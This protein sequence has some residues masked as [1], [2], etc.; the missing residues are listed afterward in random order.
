MSTLRKSFLIAMA[1]FWGATAAQSQPILFGAFANQD[2]NISQQDMLDL[3]AQVGRTLDIDNNYC[4]WAWSA[5]DTCNT[6]AQ[7]DVTSGRIPM[8]SWK[9]QQAG[10]GCA[11]PNEIIHGFYDRQL[12][13][14]AQAVA[15]LGGRVMIRFF[16][17]FNVAGSAQVKCFFAHSKDPA[18]D[19]VAA[20]QH[21]H[22]VF[23]ANGA[24]NAQWIW[25]VTPGFFNKAD[26][27]NYL[28]GSGW[29][30][31]IAI[32]TYNQNAQ[33]KGF[34]FGSFYTATLPFGLPLMVAETGAFPDANLNPD[35]QTKWLESAHLRLSRDFP[36]VQAF[37]Y[38]DSDPGNDYR[39]S[40]G[41]S[42]FAAMVNDSAFH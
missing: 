16:Y 5:S 37:V 30:D 7:W 3:E 2:G 1:L 11:K 34:S 18:G 29:V 32:D 25:C 39:L 17:E 33:V 28:P 15:A 41:I 8:I 9:V 27:K 13:A 19:F 14:Q 35:A 40:T 38:F 31:W 4:L 21:V 6:R 12:E 20:W 42:A 10:G 24:V 36:A 22:D 23:T 26:W